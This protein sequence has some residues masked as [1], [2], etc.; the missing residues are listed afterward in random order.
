MKSFWISGL[1]F[2]LMAFCVSCSDE[3]S[4]LGWNL[5]DDTEGAVFNDTTTVVAYSQLEDTIRTNGL[6]SNMVGSLQDPVFGN[7]SAA[8][9]AQFALGSSTVNFGANPVVDSVVLTL[10]VS[11]C[12]GDTNSRVG[13]RVYQLL[14]HLS[15]TDIYYQNSVVAYDPTPLNYSLQGYTVQPH[16][17]VIV[18]TNSLSPHLRIRLSQAFGQYLLN[19]QHQLNTSTSFQRVFKGLRIAAVSHT[20]ST[21]YMLTTSLT[22]SLSGITLYYHNEHQS[23]AKHTFPCNA[24]CARF[25]QFEHDYDASTNEQFVAEVLQGQHFVGENVLFVQGT[26]GVKTIIS[27]P[28]LQDAFKQYDNR[29]VINRAELVMSNVAPWEAAALATPNALALQGIRK[30]DGAIAY[31]PDDEVYTSSAYY[32][33]IYD[34]SKFEYRFR[35]TKFVQD[36]INGTCPLKPALNLVVRGASVRPNRVVLGGVGAENDKRLRLELSYTPY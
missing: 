20:G 18:D 19:N 14:D 23:S 29:V 2:L 28:Y 16:L 3:V 30:S 32:G 36:L 15:T 17:P 33:G 22:S 27:F 34:E 24:R 11:S 4:G 9:C 12:Y 10:Q 8:I 35:V 7:S 25:T 13:I 6:T 1:C 26:G 21:G 31:I 5:L